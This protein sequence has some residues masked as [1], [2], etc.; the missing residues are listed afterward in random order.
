MLFRSRVCLKL[1]SEG[2]R[3]EEIARLTD[4]PAGSVRSHIQ[5]GKLRF[6]ALW[7]TPT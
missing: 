3:F 2:Y 6:G 5:N 1:W 7:G 4:L